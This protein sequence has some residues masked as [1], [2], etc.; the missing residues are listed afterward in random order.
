MQVKSGSAFFQGF[1]LKNKPDSEEN[2]RTRSEKG[3]GRSAVNPRTN[4]SSSQPQQNAELITNR[5]SQPLKNDGND[6]NK[7]VAYTAASSS[8]SFS[9]RGVEDSNR[10]LFSLVSQKLD[11]FASNTD[12]SQINVAYASSNTALNFS[13][14]ENTANLLITKIAQVAGSFNVFSTES[15]KDGSHEDAAK[16]AAEHALTDTGKAQSSSVS[17]TANTPVVSSVEPVATQT[18]NPAK[19]GQRID[20]IRGAV[21]SGFQE[22][23]RVLQ[24]NVVL[25]PDVSN[26][27]D[28]IRQRLDDVLN[29]L[30]RSASTSIN[31]NYFKYDA[32]SETSI[33]IKT[34]DGDI[35]NINF[36]SSASQE[37]SGSSIKNN[38]LSASV[39]SYE[40][41]SQSRYSF[42]VEGNL[43][44]GELKAIEK[45]VAGIQKVSNSY[46][47]ADITSA[48][49]AIGQNSF[50]TRELQAYQFESKTVEEFKALSLYQ[51]LA[52]E[53]P[54]A[55]S[56]SPGKPINIAMGSILALFSQAGQANIVS[57]QETVLQL[58]DRLKR[59]TS[60]LTKHR[61][62]SLQFPLV[63]KK[64]STSPPLNFLK[65]SGIT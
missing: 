39:L 43:D 30:D 48:F 60:N 18:V 33:Q 7:G 27:F 34:N 50:D 19:S 42:S 36:S 31:A 61:N 51:S 12:G 21:D 16:Q 23:K 45:L 32:S 46:S 22:S 13:T 14:T 1:S 17:N 41:E 47:P 3:V 63:Q 4:L 59:Q 2:Q 11:V 65:T 58:T 52:Q 5:R 28:A 29:S 15:A 56:Q 55:V 64:S 25:S 49:A 9:F 40:S 62:P 26:A 44:E 20:A 10:L 57:P 54:D 6:D 35:V 53:E 24:Q 8:M 38:Q 37:Y